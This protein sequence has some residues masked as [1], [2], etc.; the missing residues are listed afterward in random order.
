MTRDEQ[1]LVRHLVTAVLVKLVLLTALWWLFVRD[2]GVQV[3]AD[4]MAAQIGNARPP[5]GETR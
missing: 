4:Q 1:R 5:Q 2:V 3:D